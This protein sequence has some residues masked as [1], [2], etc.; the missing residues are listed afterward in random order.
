MPRVEEHEM[1]NKKLKQAGRVA[2]YGCN[3]RGPFVQLEAKGERHQV[4]VNSDI[5]RFLEQ[6]QSLD[7]VLFDEEQ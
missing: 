7:S 3:R 5:F 4:F 1:E 2:F 6:G